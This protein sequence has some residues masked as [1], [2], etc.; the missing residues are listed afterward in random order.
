MQPL[1]ILFLG[2]GPTLHTGLARIGR[3]LAANLARDP[4]FR[5]GFLGRGGQVSRKL[6][7]QQYVFQPTAED[8]WGA[9]SLPAAVHDFCPPG[10]GPMI[11]FTVWDPSRVTW[12]GAKEFSKGEDQQLDDVL[13]DPRIRKWGYFAIDGHGA[14]PTGALTGFLC[15][16]LAGYDRILAYTAEGSQ[17]I[18]NSLVSVWDGNHEDHI[19]GNLLQNL[20]YLPHG[21][22]TSKF[23]PRSRDVAR[24]SLSIPLDAT[25]VGCAMAN[26]P[27]KDWGLWAAIGAELRSQYS[28]LRLLIKVDS[29]DRYWDLRALCQ[30]YEI[31]DITHMVLDDVSDEQMAF[32]YSAC[33]LTILPS[34]GEGFGYPIAESMAC[35]VPVVVGEYF[36]GVGRGLCAEKVK[37][38]S[39]RVD[40]RWNIIRPTYKADSWVDHIIRGLYEYE[41]NPDARD[42]L[43]TR[44]KELNWKTLWPEWLA[45]FEQGLPNRLDAEVT[46]GS[47]VGVSRGNRS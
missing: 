46:T 32:F 11:L 14:T 22:S 23:Y 19:G 20:S 42:Q 4:R 43:V 45:W 35:G 6:P 40:T 25:V 13:F 5:V 26:Q 1:P 16:T 15:E 39:T 47:E 29:L 21:I 10:E 17:V 41:G 18:R 30:D 33:D 2:D 31:A 38:V 8:E 34:L 44:A 9:G 7:F 37:P 24:S 36:S 3:H 12:I 27:R 28:E